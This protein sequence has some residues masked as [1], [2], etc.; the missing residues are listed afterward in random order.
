MR[1]EEHNGDNLSSFCTKC[2]VLVCSSCLLYGKHREHNN[3]TMFVGDA[4]NWYRQEFQKFSPDVQNQRRRMEAAL[5][6]VERMNDSVQEM[7]GRLEKEADE[8]YGELINLIEARRD[9]LKM[10]IMKRTQMRVEALTDQAM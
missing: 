4:A 9:N 5:G 8:A 10:D 3:K 6:D 7:G 1:C 2:G